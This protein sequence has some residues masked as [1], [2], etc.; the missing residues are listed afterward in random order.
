MRL[1]VQYR[2]SEF[3]NSSKNCSGTANS[4]TTDLILT[5]AFRKI[6]DYNHRYISDIFVAITLSFT[7]SLKTLY[8]DNN[9]VNCNKIN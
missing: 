4:Y 2:V 9:F 5:R 3:K 7:K 6:T 8:I 1:A